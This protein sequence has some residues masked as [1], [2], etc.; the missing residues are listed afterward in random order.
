MFPLV[1]WALVR[2]SLKV[3]YCASRASPRRVCLTSILEAV[4]QDL[5]S[6]VPAAQPILTLTLFSIC[7][8]LIGEIYSEPAVQRLASPRR[9]CL[10][11]L[12]TNTILCACT[13]FRVHYMG[14]FHPGLKLSPD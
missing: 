6:I 13:G 10:T 5:L 2:C 7:L 1:A 11:S 9:V 14:E 4:V 8:L 3:A 12:I